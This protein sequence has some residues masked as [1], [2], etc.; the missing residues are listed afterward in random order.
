MIPPTELRAWAAILGNIVYPFEYDILMSMDA[1]YC[2]EIN[3]EI[4]SIQSKK[5]ESKK[6]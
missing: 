5:E 6:G 4:A 1:V 2:D 3:K